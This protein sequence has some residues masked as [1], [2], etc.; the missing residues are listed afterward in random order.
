[1]R[2]QRV[3]NLMDSA[4]QYVTNSAVISRET[5]IAAAKSRCGP[6]CRISSNIPS[7]MRSK[8]PPII[9][10]STGSSSLTHATLI[11]VCSIPTVNFGTSG[12]CLAALSAHVTASRV[13]IGSMMRSIHNRAAP[14]RGS[15]C[16]V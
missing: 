12:L 2:T 9:P 15:I 13:S 5:K 7:G 6:G 16:R 3:R 14:Y 8:T 1:M 10:S 11:Y 4:S